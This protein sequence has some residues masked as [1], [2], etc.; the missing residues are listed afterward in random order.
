MCETD[1]HS[2]TSLGLEPN[3]TECS[4]D[5]KKIILSQLTLPAVVQMITTLTLSTEKNPDM[6][7]VARSSQS[8]SESRHTRDA[9]G[10]NASS[11][12]GRTTPQC[13]LIKRGVQVLVRQGSVEILLL[14]VDHHTFSW[15]RF[16][17][18]PY[19]LATCFAL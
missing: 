2:I 9:H 4:L 12:S 14:F 8:Q 16:V 18:G 10:P 15:Q 11:N 17:R 19:M 5:N 13:D 3:R 1:L 6:I 7:Q